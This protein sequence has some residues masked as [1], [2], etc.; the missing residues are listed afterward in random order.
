MP[1][2][3]RTIS[4]R[5]SSATLRVL[6]KGA[7]KTGMPRLRAHSRSTWLVPMQKHPTPIS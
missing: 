7:L 6:E 3:S 4:A 1:R 5:T 2:R